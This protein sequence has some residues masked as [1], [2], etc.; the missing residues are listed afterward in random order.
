MGGGVSVIKDL[1]ENEKLYLKYSK[2]IDKSLWLFLVL[3]EIKCGCIIEY[4]LEYINEITE[5]ELILLNKKLNWFR[6]EN[7][8]DDKNLIGIQFLISNK[9]IDN[10]FFE[11]NDSK[12][13][14]DYINYLI[15]D[16]IYLHNYYLNEDITINYYHIV[17]NKKEKIYEIQLKRENFSVEAIY[18]A[19]EEKNQ[20]EYNIKKLMPIL[21]AKCEIKIDFYVEK[22]L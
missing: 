17:D 3:E 20:L 4:N 16:N 11:T 19:E 5:F 10:S 21:F 15:G 1:N 14:Y 7:M 18:A 13:Y 12:K 8:S 9:K 22:N 2:T 6:I